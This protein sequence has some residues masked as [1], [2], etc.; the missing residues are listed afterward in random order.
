MFT[1]EKAVVEP[2][3]QSKQVTNQTSWRNTLPK[4]WFV[5]IERDIQT[6]SSKDNKSTER[7]P[8]SD[9]YCSAMPAKRRKIFTAKS[10]LQDKQMF[11]KVLSRTLEK[12]QLKQN[13]SGENL[14]EEGLVNNQLIGNFISE[15]NTSITERL[16]TD[17]DFDTVLKKQ[18]DSSS[19]LIN[20][21]RFSNLKKRFN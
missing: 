21:D 11:K 10:D 13:V 6:Q 12:I 1:E 2:T 19:D 9:A 15:F 20:K 4:E 18:E 16:R 5:D 3:K 17:T 14:I 8:F 7:A